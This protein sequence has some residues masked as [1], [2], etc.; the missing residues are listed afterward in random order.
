MFVDDKASCMKANKTQHLFQ[1]N[2]VKFW[3]ND[4]WPGNSPDLNAAEH[5]GSI[6]KDEV[7]KNCYPKL[8][9][10]VSRSNTQKPHRKCFKKLIDSDYEIE[11]NIY[12]AGFKHV[13]S[14]IVSIT[15]QHLNSVLSTTTADGGNSN[16][17]YIRRDQ[18][19]KFISKYTSNVRTMIYMEKPGSDPSTLTSGLDEQFTALLHEGKRCHSHSL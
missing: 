7:E 1:D 13:S 11:V 3:G 6:T 15:G 8:E 19:K 5:V 9:T 18:A 4:I 10:I 16:A 2:D 12:F 17:K 14:N